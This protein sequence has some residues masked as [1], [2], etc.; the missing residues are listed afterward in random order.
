A[1]GAGARNRRV[2][3]A[4]LRRRSCG[5]RGCRR[6]H[7]RRA[8][9]PVL[10]AGRRRSFRAG[11]HADPVTNPESAAVTVRPSAPKFAID[12]RWLGKGLDQCRIEAGPDG[13]VWV[14]DRAGDAAS[15]WSAG[16]G[17][18]LIVA[19]VYNHV[20]RIN[21]WQQLLF[22]APD[23]KTLGKSRRMDEATFGQIWPDE[24][25]A[26]LPGAGL[27]VS[28]EKFGT[29]RKLNRAHP[30]SEPRWLLKQYPQNALLGGL[31]LF[32]LIILIT[33]LATAG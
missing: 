7:R 23:G 2:R 3:R 31:L 28:H 25:L 21:Y 11:W 17:V 5:R 10:T 19:A 6:G 32:G 12:R 26:R 33:F 18:Q 27:T 22:C 30:G 8:V 1:R 29:Y 9:H 24:V 16:E 15:R 14:P 20:G 4:D 13:V